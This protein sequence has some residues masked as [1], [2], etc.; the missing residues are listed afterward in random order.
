MP[1]VAVCLL[2]FM[3]VACTS[4]PPP[5]S[6]GLQAVTAIPTL[7]RNNPTGLCAVV[8]SAWGRDWPRVITALEILREL[9]AA[10]SDSYRV[11]ARLYTAYIAY[12]TALEGRGERQRAIRAYQT[13]LV[14]NFSGGEAIRRLQALEVF[15]PE[16]PPSCS[17]E[18]VQGFIGTLPE[19]T[20]TVGDFVTIQ[21]GRFY[22]GDVP[23]VVYGVNYYPRD[24]P[25]EYFLTQMDV[26]AVGLELDILQTAGF[27]TL[28]IYLRHDDL[29]TCPGNGAIPIA[30][31]FDR[32]DRFIQAAAGRGYKLIL[33]LNHDPDLVAYPLYESPQHTTEQITFIVNRYRDEP[34]I[35]AYDL[36]DSGDSDY[37][38]DNAQF[39]ATQVLTWLA[40]AAALVRQIAPSQL[41]TAGWRT[42]AAVTAPLVEFVSFQHFGDVEL[43]RQEISL[44]RSQTSRPLL[45]TSIGYNTQTIDETEQLQAFQRAFEAAEQNNLAGWVV[46]TAF[47]FPSSVLC[48]L[49]STVIECESGAPQTAS[50]GLWQQSYFPKLAVQAVEFATG[51][52]DDS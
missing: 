47:D 38:G 25:F 18:R 13:A 8:D 32:L 36:R 51:I 14:Y 17:P 15:T 52:I 6:D 28:R 4:V 5:P 46:W 43:L 22:L 42:D 34:A 27:N 7:D 39:T 16:P 49:P 40:D 26:E 10:C 21:G 30:I 50:W 12:G 41:V 44:L 9:D 33:V 31:N 48:T 45:L 24:Y 37:N 19:Y 1:G 20:P 3:L 11:D 23:Y 35:M 29:F 2:V